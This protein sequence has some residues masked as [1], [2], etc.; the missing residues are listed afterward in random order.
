MKVKFSR[1]NSN[2]LTNVPQVDGQL[3]YVKDTNEVYMDVGNNRNKISDVI[4]VADITNV[5]NPIISK[6][7]Y[8]EAT[9][10]LYKYID[11]EWKSLGESV[12]PQIYFWDGNTQA[13]GL[14]LWNT[15]MKANDNTDVVVLYKFSDYDL[16]AIIKIPQG[17][18]RTT[19]KTDWFDYYN[20]VSTNTNMT[21]S[22]MKSRINFT[23]VNNEITTFNVTTST[24][25][26]VNLLEIDKDYTTPYTPQFNGSPATKKYVEDTIATKLGAIDDILDDINGEEV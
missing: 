2:S 24:V 23:I 9:E 15:V 11:N 8:D 16:S 7:Y 25:M 6:I 18:I 14:A 17:T 13:K 1:C 19:Q 21:Y 3:I 22:A 12:T 4:E 10:N 5:Q 20:L 26:S